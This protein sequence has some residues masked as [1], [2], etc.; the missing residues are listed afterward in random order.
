MNYRGPI[1]EATG[2]NNIVDDIYEGNEVK[3]RRQAV[4]K[5]VHPV[6]GK[7]KGGKKNQNHESRIISGTKKGK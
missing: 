1:G 2:K 4:K 3:G 7:G 5:A 6:S